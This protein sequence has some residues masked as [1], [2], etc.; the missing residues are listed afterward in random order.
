M[1]P[2]INWEYKEDLGINTKMKEV[3][4]ATLKACEAERDKLRAKL[5]KLQYGG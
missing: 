4:R 2:K 1:K 5:E 3:L